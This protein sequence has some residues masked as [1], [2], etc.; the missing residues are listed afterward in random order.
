MWR[1]SRTIIR[2]AVNSGLPSEEEHIGVGSKLARLSTR[3]TNRVEA[4]CCQASVLSHPPRSLPCPR[5][6]FFC[7]RVVFIPVIKK[8]DM[9]ISSKET[10]SHQSAPQV[11]GAQK[12]YMCSAG[13]PGLW[14]E[15]VTFVVQYVFCYPSKCDFCNF[16]S[17]FVVKRVFP[18]SAGEML[19]CKQHTVSDIFSDPIIPPHTGKKQL[20]QKSYMLHYV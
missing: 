15:L 2:K 17:R 1:V 9:V 18:I 6:P 5:L 11:R 16:S 13:G 19:L 14:R 3:T 4:S 8:W 10:L 20:P 7:K 12:I